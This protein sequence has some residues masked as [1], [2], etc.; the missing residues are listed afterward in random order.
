LVSL[1]PTPAFWRVASDVESTTQLDGEFHLFFVQ[2]NA[3]QNVA[4]LIPDADSD[5]DQVRIVSRQFIQYAPGMLLGML[6][7]GKFVTL[8]CWLAA[9]PFDIKEKLRHVVFLN[10][11]RT[12]SVTKS[13]LE[14]ES[15]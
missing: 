6:Q 8:L 15:F 5:V 9:G 11:R 12:V 7:G 2:S 4:L 3:I 1:P 13:F 14:P 10:Q